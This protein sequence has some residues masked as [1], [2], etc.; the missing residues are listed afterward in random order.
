MGEVIGA[1]SAGRVHRAFD[2][3]LKRNVILKFLQC[4][5]SKRQTKRFRAEALALSKLSHPN[6]VHLYE[7]VEDAKRPFLVLEDID[8]TSLDELMD[9]GILEPNRALEIIFDCAL[10]LQAAHEAGIV[11]RD[12]KP[13][14]VIISPEGKAKLID[15]GL[16]LDISG[17]ISTRMTEDGCVIGTLAYM[18]PEML[19]GE[20][21]TENS[22]IYALGVTFYEMLTHHLPY[23]QVHF[24]ALMMPG[25]NIQVQEDKWPESVDLRLRELITSLVTLSAKERPTKVSAVIEQLKNLT[26]KVYSKPTVVSPRV[27]QR[28]SAKKDTKPLSGKDNE[29]RKQACRRK[30]RAVFLARGSFAGAEEGAKTSAEAG[31]LNRLSHILVLL[32][33]Q[34]RLGLKGYGEGGERERPADDPLPS[35]YLARFYLARYGAEKDLAPQIVASLYEGLID[36]HLSLAGT[37]I[38]DEAKSSNSDGTGVS[39]DNIVR[40]SSTAKVGNVEGVLELYFHWVK[41]HQLF[42]EAAKFLSELSERR[43]SKVMLPLIHRLAEEMLRDCDERRKDIK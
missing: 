28:D 32:G 2:Q 22:D 20:E 10:G 36:T 29:A 15:F 38:I 6:V 12:F 21:A 31:K 1:G 19:R 17:D 9:S 33:F 3:R 5:E 30:R 8:G 11:H 42:S 24:A 7:Y 4:S 41:K 18:A 14:N 16:L 34:K 27:R 23:E 39:A 37:D 13:G 26:C 25:N 40:A 35:D 43:G